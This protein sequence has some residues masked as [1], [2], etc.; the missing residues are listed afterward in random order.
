MKTD[1]F[2]GFN[3]VLCMVA[4]GQKDLR[5][6][7]AKAGDEVD[8]IGTLYNEFM[9]G[10]R[11]RGNDFIKQIEQAFRQ[12]WG[13][14]AYAPPETRGAIIASINDIVNNPINLAS[15]DVRQSAAFIVS[16]LVSTTQSAAH[17]GNMLD[18]I[19]V[20]MGDAPGEAAGRAT[21]AQL[22]AGT[23]FEGCVDQASVR[24]ASAQPVRHRPFLRN[25]E[26]D[27]VV[28]TLPLH[29]PSSLV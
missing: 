8:S 20:A 29:H 24:L 19:T 25:D 17:M 12:R 5:E 23:R 22:V 21:I 4:T 15:W 28:A 14:Y 2:T 11:Q 26:G 18:R 10:M 6:V 16:E 1:I 13:W 7:M 9:D 27:F 3:Q